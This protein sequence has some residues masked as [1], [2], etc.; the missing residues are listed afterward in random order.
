MESVQQEKIKVKYY[1]RAVREIDKANETLKKAGKEDRFYVDKKQ[2][3]TACGIA[4]NAVLLALDGYLLI[5]GIEVKKGKK[6]ISFYKKS[7]SEV[8]IKLL[9]YVTEAYNILYLAGHYDGSRAS[10]VILAGFELAFVIINK[11]KPVE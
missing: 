11:I 10:K 2:V 5:C 1:T 6:D 8:D 9:N 3:K 7:V 4:Y